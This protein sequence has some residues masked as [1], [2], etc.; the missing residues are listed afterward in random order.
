MKFEQSFFVAA[1]RSNV[2]DFFETQGEAVGACIPGMQ[3]ITSTGPDSYHLVI[4]Q[5]VGTL[6]ATFD[7]KAEIK[8]KDPI[9]SLKLTAA[10]RS[11]KGARGDLRA[12]AVV[13]LDEVDGGTQVTLNAEVML[14]G[15]LG[16]L[17]QKV[18]AQRAADIIEVF[19]AE[20]A[21]KVR[22]SSIGD[23][24]S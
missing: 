17:G 15:M 11:I 16:S 5:K 3:E 1:P 20:L 14:A 22:D 6:G 18:I 13:T 10:G 24:A 12:S 9:S 2:W 23:A 21:A 7:M 8:E 19:S 4:T